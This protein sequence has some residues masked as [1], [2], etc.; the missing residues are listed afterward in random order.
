[1]RS[2]EARPVARESRIVATCTFFRQAVTPR[3]SLFSRF[4][5]L[6]FVFAQPALKPHPKF[7]WGES[8]D[9]NDHVNHDD[10]GH[11]RLQTPF[12]QPLAPDDAGGPGRPGYMGQLK[13]GRSGDRV[14]RCGST[15]FR[16]EFAAP[17]SPNPA[18][19]RPGTVFGNARKNARKNDSAISR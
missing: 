5:C 6:F 3:K 14:F 7:A 4:L 16:T 8:A 9:F 12:T 10:N 17:G 1:M 18:T 19:D 2:N 15:E 13:I 11:A